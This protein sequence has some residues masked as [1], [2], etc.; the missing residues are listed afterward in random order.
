M[1]FVYRRVNP[2]IVG[3]RTGQRCRD[4]SFPKAAGSSPWGRKV[5]SSGASRAACDAKKE[6]S[7]YQ[8]KS[9]INQCIQKKRGNTNRQGVFA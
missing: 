5:A 1:K 7:Q 4:A 3:P 2:H 6:E 8:R 9:L